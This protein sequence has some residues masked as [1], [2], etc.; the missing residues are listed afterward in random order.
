MPVGTPRSDWGPRRGYR[1]GGRDPDELAGGAVKANSDESPPIEG[2]PLRESDERRKPKRRG[3][4]EGR[5]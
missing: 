5:S 1:G 2:V 3:K 4:S